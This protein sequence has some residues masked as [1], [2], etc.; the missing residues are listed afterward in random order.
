MNSSLNMLKW[1]LPFDFSLLDS[2]FRQAWNRTKWD[3]IILFPVIVITQCYTILIPISLGLLIELSF[4][5]NS[6]RT[7]IFRFLPDHWLSTSQKVFFFFLILLCLKFVF[8]WYSKY[9]RD[10]IGVE[11]SKSLQQTLFTKQLQIPPNHYHDKGTGKYLLRWSGDLT[12]IQNWISK[13]ILQFVSDSILFL[14]CMVLLIYWFEEIAWQIVISWVVSFTILLIHGKYL[15]KRSNH[16]RNKRSLLLSHVHQRLQG[17]EMIQV[18]NR[19]IPEYKRFEKKLVQSVDT[20][21]KYLAIRSYIFAIAPFLFFMWLGYILYQASELSPEKKSMFVPAVLVLLSL[22]SV[23]RRMFRAIIHWKNGNISL[24]KL[25]KIMKKGENTDNQKARYR[26]KKGYLVVE[27]LTHQYPNGRVVLQN[28]CVRIEGPGLYCIPL[29]P[30]KG[31]STLIRLLTGGLPVSNQTIY[32]DK[33]D[34]CKLNIKSLRRKIVVVSS[35]YPLIGD[36]VFEAISYSRNKDNIPHAKKILNEFQK[37]LP[38]EERLTL[39]SKIGEM[40]IMLSDYQKAL[41]KFCRAFLTEKPIIIIEKPWENLNEDV[42]NIIIQ[43][44]SVLK[45]TSTIIILDTYKNISYLPN[46]NLNEFRII[47]LTSLPAIPSQ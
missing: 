34:M 43:K 28:A 33:Q 40:G 1:M 30:G 17:I 27:K 37:N 12:S 26:Y 44:L 42:I 38:R 3:I 5:H 4:S 31:K 39:E 24:R 41:L 46:T 19:Q 20:Q 29:E 16:K 15:S 32:W 18:F 22:S 35:I 45:N 25:E 7:Q 9:L 14:V 10:S 2:S 36:N 11:I 8:E 13:G 23:F 21:K 6:F 47:P